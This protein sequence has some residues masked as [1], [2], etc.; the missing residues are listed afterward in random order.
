MEQDRRDGRLQNRLRRAEDREGRRPEGRHSAPRT[1]IRE[2]S[3][4]TKTAAD[5]DG[6]RSGCPPIQSVNVPDRHHHWRKTLLPRGLL[7][8]AGGEGGVVGDEGQFVGDVEHHPPTA[9]ANTPQPRIG[10]VDPEVVGHHV[11]AVVDG[12]VGFELVGHPQRRFGV[13]QPQAFR[14]RRPRVAAGRG[15]QPA[16]QLPDE[17]EMVQSGARRRSPVR[18]RRRGRR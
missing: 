16:D 15:E 13:D 2:T 6:A 1:P 12:A 14:I 4:A 17:T 3:G 7:P 11:D 9:A 5:R 10:A 8:R 18:A